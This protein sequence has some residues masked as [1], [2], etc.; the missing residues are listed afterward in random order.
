[1]I[2]AVHEMKPRYL[3]GVEETMD[4]FVRDVKRNVGNARAGLSQ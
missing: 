3:T 1:M 2:A 4:S